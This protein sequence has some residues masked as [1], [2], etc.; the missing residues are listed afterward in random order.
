MIFI[1]TSIFTEDCKELLGD[2][3]YREFQ[4]YLAD[5]PTAGDVIQHTGGL[6]KVRWASR[7]KGKR[8]GV[9]VIYYYKVDVSHIRLLLI[10]KKGVKDDLSE[11]E[12]K[13]LRALNERW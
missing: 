2:D 7:G 1:E 13:V 3:E 12:K 4:Q 9:R 8:G 6:R 10:Y 11:S 5:N